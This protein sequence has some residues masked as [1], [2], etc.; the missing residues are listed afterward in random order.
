MTERKRKTSY[1]FLRPDSQ[2]WHVRLQSPGGRIEKSLGTP[3]RAQAE[4]LALP[5]IQQHK[6]RLLEA[7]PESSHLAVEHWR[8]RAGTRHAI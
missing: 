8:A 3:D 2:N 7:K 6:M 1:L 5:Y 4:I